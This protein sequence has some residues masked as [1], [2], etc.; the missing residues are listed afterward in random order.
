MTRALLVLALTLGGWSAASEPI[1]SVPFEDPETGFRLLIPSDWDYAVAPGDHR[2]VK[3]AHAD[4]IGDYL[5]NEFYYPTPAAFIDLR[6]GLVAYSCLHAPDAQHWEIDGQPA[7]GTEQQ[8]Y[9]EAAGVTMVGREV[10]FVAPNGQ[11]IVI[12]VYTCLECEEIL[13]VFDA[14]VASISWLAR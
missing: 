10:T 14:M 6:P 9:D 11:V 12:D 5:A 4:V 1:V 8:G 13:D 3:F 2:Y 7:C